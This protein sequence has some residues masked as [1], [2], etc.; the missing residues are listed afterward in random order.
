M[1]RHVMLNWTN[2]IKDEAQKRNGKYVNHFFIGIPTIL[3]DVEKNKIKIY[4]VPGKLHFKAS[5]VNPYIFLGKDL[6][7]SINKY[8]GENRNLPKPTTSNDQ[9]N[10][11]YGLYTRNPDIAYELLEQGTANKFIELKP[12]SPR[13][14]IYDKT[15]IFE[16]RDIDNEPS[17]LSTFVSAGL[18]ILNKFLLIIN[19]KRL[20]KI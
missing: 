19:N 12:F 14:F 18:D 8:L 17:I 15:F 20:N 16:C 5:L 13:L 4:R 3:L 9:F 6:G 1:A 11:Y 10:S 2:L 7:V